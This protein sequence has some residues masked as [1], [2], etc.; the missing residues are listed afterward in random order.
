MAISLNFLGID[1]DNIQTTDKKPYDGI[2]HINK[3]MLQSAFIKLIRLL[4]N[5]RGE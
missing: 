5:E 3:E 4:P 2:D 1:L